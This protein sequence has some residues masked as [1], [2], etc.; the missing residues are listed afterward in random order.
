MAEYGA[1]SSIMYDKKIF[2]HLKRIRADLELRTL[3]LNSGNAN[4]QKR[5]I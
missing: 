3:V 5:A 2:A 4:D 1:V